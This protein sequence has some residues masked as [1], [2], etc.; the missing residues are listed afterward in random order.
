VAESATVLVETPS[1]LVGLFRQRCRIV[2]GHRQVLDILGRVPYTLEAL[3]RRRPELAAR[4]VAAE[5][6]E[7]PWRTLAFLGLALPLE[8]VAHIS[9]AIDGALGMRVPSA[10][11]TVD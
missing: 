11:A 5:L 9:A 10:W 3:V 4:I 8:V 6:S 7:R 1:N 2:R